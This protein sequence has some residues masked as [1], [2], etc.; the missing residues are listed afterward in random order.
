M[1]CKVNRR[2]FLGQT[3]AAAGAVSVPLVIKASV[4]G[5]ESA[6]PP[7]DKV[8]IGCIGVGG[9]GTGNMNAFLGLEDCRVVAVCDTYKDRQEKAKTLVDTE[10]GDSG[11]AMYGDYREVLARS[12]I[13]AV[14]IAAQDHWHALIAVAAAAAG[15]DMYCEKPLGVSV[16]EGQRIRDCGSPGQASLPDGNL[17]TI[18][19]DIPARL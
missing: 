14:M 5:G 8:T 9:M 13:D 17:A 15:K 1:T 4:L 12:D 2:Q 11:C 16:E 18:P 6:T 7:S 10:Y 19:A 3:M